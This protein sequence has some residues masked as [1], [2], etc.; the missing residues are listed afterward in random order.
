MELAPLDAITR[1]G[2]V[3]LDHLANNPQLTQEQ[4]VAEAC[5]HF[6]AIL[7]RQ[8]LRD[9]QRTIL[10]SK[11]VPE[12]FS[13]SIYQDMISEQMADSI[14]R[15]GHFGLAHSFNHQVSP[16]SKK[17]S[18]VAASAPAETRLVSHDSST[19]DALQ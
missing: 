13:S 10:P 15:S 7:L 18:V 17:P 2:N 4:K 11:I 6:E 16:P 14:S 5:R 1:P 3:A 8:I 12:S 19:L 9:T